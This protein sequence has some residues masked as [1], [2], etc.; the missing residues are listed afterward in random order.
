MQ[1]PITLFIVDDQPLFR[2]GLRACL[3]EVDDIRIEGECSVTEDALELVDSFAPNVALLDAAPPRQRGLDLARRISQRSPNT[4]IIIMSPMPQD[5]ELFEAIRSGARAYLSKQ[6]TAK[7]IIA[8]IRQVHLG[9]FPL[10]ESLLGHPK[11]AERVLLEFQNLARNQ[12]LDGL[13][14]PLSRREMEVLEHIRDGYINKEIAHRLCLTEQTVKSH[15]TSILR[16]LDVNDRTQAVLT[17]VRLGWISLHREE[18]S[19]SQQL[20]KG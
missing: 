14:A 2:M 18:I 11:V 13:T 20:A 19:Q 6:A 7:D 15:V 12:R 5:T 16:K 3:A 17:A 10:N 9:D 1:K 8:T 4:A